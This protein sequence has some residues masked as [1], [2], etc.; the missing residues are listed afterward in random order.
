MIPILTTFL[1][2]LSFTYLCELRGWKIA[3][4]NED[5]T[6]SSSLTGFKEERVHC[7]FVFFSFTKYS[8]ILTVWQVRGWVDEM[9][10]TVT[11]PA[12]AEAA[13]QWSTRAV[14]K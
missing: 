11:V 10:K 2:I 14:S 12:S 13:F 5:G 6:Q 1:L 7:S 4:Q 3:Q 8:L 9:D